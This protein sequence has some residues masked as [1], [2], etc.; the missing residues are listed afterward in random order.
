MIRNGASKTL[1]LDPDQKL[2]GIVALVDLLG[3]AR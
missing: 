1:I 2:L 3:Q